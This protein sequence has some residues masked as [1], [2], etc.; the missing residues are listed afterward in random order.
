[1]KRLRDYDTKT[2]SDTKDNKLNII[3]EEF[4]IQSKMYCI[5]YYKDVIKEKEDECIFLVMISEE[6][7]ISHNL[8]DNGSVFSVLLDKNSV[9]LLSI[10]YYHKITLKSCING[11]K[12][13]LGLLHFILHSIDDKKAYLRD[14]DYCS[15]LQSLK[16]LIIPSFYVLSSMESSR[17]YF[18]FK[19]KTNNIIVL[20]QQQILS[21][22]YF[23]SNES[24]H[25]QQIACF[26]FDNN[27]NLLDLFVKSS[28]N[29]INHHH[30]KKIKKMLPKTLINNKFNEEYEKETLKTLYDNLF[31]YI[32]Q[33]QQKNKINASNTI[34]FG[35]II[36]DE[37][38]SEDITKDT[39][40]SKLNL[41]NNSKRLLCYRMNGK[42][43]D[44]EY[45]IRSLLYDNRI[46]TINDINGHNNFKFSCE[47][48]LQ[49]VYRF[50]RS[51]KLIYYY[52]DGFD[53]VGDDGNIKDVIEKKRLL[54]ETC[55]EIKGESV[56][57][58]LEHEKN[59]T[60]IIDK[61]SFTTNILPLFLTQLTKSKKNNIKEL[62]KLISSYLNIKL[63]QTAFKKS[64][65][66]NSSLYNINI[67]HLVWCINSVF[68]IKDVTKNNEISDNN[69]PSHSHC[70]CIGIYKS[71][72]LLEDFFVQKISIMDIINEY[73][74]NIDIFWSDYK[75]NEDNKWVIDGHIY[76]MFKKLNNTYTDSGD[77][78]ADAVDIEYYNNNINKFC[79][80]NILYCITNES[81]FEQEKVVYK[82]FKKPSTQ[83]NSFIVD[84]KILY[85]A[86]VEKEHS[87]L[88]T[89]LENRILNIF[90]QATYSSIMDEK[91]SM[92]KS[93]IY[94]IPHDGDIVNINKII[95]A[96][97]GCISKFYFGYSII[98]PT[99]ENIVGLDD[100]IFFNKMLIEGKHKR[101][102]VVC[103]QTKPEE[104]DEMEE[105]V[106]STQP[107]IHDKNLKEEDKICFPIC[108]IG[109]IR[110]NKLK[111]LIIINSDYISVSSM[112][113]LLYF[114][115]SKGKRNYIEKVLFIGSINSKPLIHKY[116]NGQS[117]IDSI[118]ILDGNNDLFINSFMKLSRTR[119][120][121][122]NIQK[123][124]KSYRKQSYYTSQLSTIEKTK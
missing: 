71:V 69:S 66:T 115:Y 78:D 120:V 9:I 8:G 37:T 42:L 57:M 58:K 74:C 33:Y 109:E 3:T 28:D 55:D 113:L 50:I 20:E 94:F 61:I 95:Y 46:F 123:N 53:A 63:K 93:Q 119:S 15:S 25:P 49:I 48:H 59:Y 60:W 23:N 108:D 47:K 40:L 118:R 121:D 100:A 31:K 103:T 17:S 117:F 72:Y 36:G 122:N 83:L 77:A 110:S 86:E 6:P 116:I 99:H 27:K 106:S 29:G 111:T 5:G 82:F 97:S 104:E 52:G 16:Q 45:N 101:L 39:L 75:T 4:Y 92:K 32:K 85:Q 44:L 51:L 35:N 88:N 70:N 114:I 54:R 12:T 73:L 90:E 84:T 19:K 102:P 43:M 81:I 7:V 65:E 41:N 13:K 14:K 34:C 80:K 67:H 1:M 10:F 11:I 24:E 107:I 64:N 96:L 26:S 62:T 91:A 21:S 68:G 87:L 112:I 76:D 124:M 18:C 105:W 22:I 98:Y 89:G 2:E 79:L 30:D 38:E 56:L